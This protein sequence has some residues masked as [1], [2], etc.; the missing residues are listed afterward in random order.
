M[1]RWMGDVIGRFVVVLDRRSRLRAVIVGLLDRFPTAKPGLKRAL[2]KARAAAKQRRSGPGAADG[3]LTVRAA[4][5][6]DDLD[7]ERARLAGSRG[8]R[9]SG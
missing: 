9:G 8:D 4:H 1:T 2:A 7:R 6:L 5:V 3:T